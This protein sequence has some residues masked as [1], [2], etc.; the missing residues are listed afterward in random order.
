MNIPAKGDVC[1]SSYS[2]GS[3]PE[4]HSWRQPKYGL[5]DPISTSKQLGVV[6]RACHPSCTRCINRIMSQADMGMKVRP[7]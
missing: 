1:M 2:G 3:D 7:L 6:T 5:E 4:N